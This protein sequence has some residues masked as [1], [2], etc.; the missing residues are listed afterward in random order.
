MTDLTWLIIV[1]LVVAAM[2]LHT[3]FFR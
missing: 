1:G 2:V 3:A